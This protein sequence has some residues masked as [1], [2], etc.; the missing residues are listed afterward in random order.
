VLSIC[1]GHLLL[2]QSAAPI[3]LVHFRHSL[4]YTLLCPPSAT[5]IVVLR[6]AYT[7]RCESHGQTPLSTPKLR[8][9]AHACCHLVPAVSCPA[10]AAACRASTP[11]RP[12]ATAPPLSVSPCS[13]Q[14]QSWQAHIQQL[15]AALIAARHMLS[16]LVF[17]QKRVLQLHGSNI[18]LISSPHAVA[19]PLHRSGKCSRH[20]RVRCEVLTS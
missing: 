19:K 14:Q 11:C 4:L 12:P 16:A 17:E 7:A 5:A 1:A 15:G 9:P 18:Q 6:H 20:A 3:F 2:S 13:R 10:A 8:P